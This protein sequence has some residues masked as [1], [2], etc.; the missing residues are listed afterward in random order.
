MQIAICDDNEI[1]RQELREYLEEY[2]DEKNI[3]MKLSE[4][5]NGNDLLQADIKHD[6]IFLDYR[7]EGENGLDIAKKI[8]RKDKK[9]GL[10][11][12]T[13]FP[14]FVFDSFEVQPFRFI[15]KP[16]EK[17]KVFEAVESYLKQMRNNRPVSVTEDGKHIVIMT[18][19]IVYIVSKGKKCR[20]VTKNNV[21]NVSNTLLSLSSELPESCFYRI[22]RSHI[23]NLKNIKMIRGN[24][25]TMT[26][27]SVLSVSRSKIREFRE[28]YF[29][30]V[31]DNYF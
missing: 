22:H 28:H 6:I 29:D 15:V 20:I 27:D 3:C 10:V 8:R 5:S 26:D 11:F 13:A 18:D 21:Y 1:F 23:V 12:V 30:Y 19:D 16:A 2:G 25:V 14:Q 17:E 7:M 24:V 31:E 9:C 4:Y